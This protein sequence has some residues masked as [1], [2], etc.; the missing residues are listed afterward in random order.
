MASQLPLENVELFWSVIQEGNIK[1]IVDLNGVE[2]MYNTDCSV[3]QA[4]IIS[5]SNNNKITL[6]SY[7]LNSKK[8][9]NRLVYSQW[10]N[11]LGIKPEN[12][13]FLI[14]QIEKYD[15]VCIHGLAGVG[16][17]GTLIVA[18]ALSEMISHEEITEEN[19]LDQMDALI[20]E[21]RKQRG[22]SFVQTPDQYQAIYD[23]AFYRLKR[24]V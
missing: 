13:N 14:N 11:Y 7:V 23:W 3:Q 2:D 6:F 16:R 12:L 18:L 1:F 10:N 15:N 17:T 5:D 4:G 20:L 24:S 21:G 19:L 22:V 9:I 8:I